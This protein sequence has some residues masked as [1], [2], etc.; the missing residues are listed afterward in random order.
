MNYR[1]LMI[2]GTSSACGKSLTVLAL[3]KILKKKGIKPCPFKAQNM[4]L[5]SYATELGELSYAQFLQAKA[6]GLIPHPRYN[7]FL[8]KPANNGIFLIKMGKPAGFY[9]IRQYWNNM[10]KN[11][12][13]IKQKIEE[14]ER[15]F[16]LIV[17]EGAGSPAEPNLMQFDLANLKT[18]KLLKAK[19]I[20]V[21][22]IERG[23]CFSAIL[24]TLQILGR[25]AKQ[26]NAL[27]INKFRGNRELLKP[28]ISFIEKKTG[29]K[30]LGIIPYIEEFQLPEEDS[31]FDLKK[32]QAK[33]K[34]AI[35][36]LPHLCNFSDFAP[37]VNE[38][39]VRLYL[40]LDAEEIMGADLLIIPGTRKTV[41]DLK[42]LK[43]KGLDKVIL[44]YEKKGGFIIAIC[45]GLQILGEK[46]IDSGI[47]DEAIEKGIGILKLN[48]TFL[49]D[50]KLREVKGIDLESKAK[51]KG[52]EIH[53]GDSQADGIESA[54]LLDDGRYEGYRRGNIIATYIHGIL[55][56]D[57]FRHWILRKVAQKK[58]IKELN[59][60]RYKLEEKLG[61]LASIF[62]QNIDLNFL[63]SII[64]DKM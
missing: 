25:E 42:Y 17:A 21:A 31:L 61:R 5:N 36:N 6:I 29:I 18:Q 47:E 58:A 51:I 35:L 4:S 52:Y 49:K 43:K 27:L 62:E 38:P 7:P 30:V 24:G 50:K 9:N 46:I 60:K 15:E 32:N 37:L 63:F 1:N 23:G 54:F 3:L 40:T 57:E 28:A 48:T 34:V 56:S 12:K 45:G 8:L 11:L 16:D 59:L 39:E 14:L 26:I 41:S 44:S 64:E 20:L 13:L 19:V 2:W 10:G 22:D 33:I 55:E 53:H